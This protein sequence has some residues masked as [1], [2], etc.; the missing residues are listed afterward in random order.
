VAGY[1]PYQVV[2]GHPSGLIEYSTVRH[3]IPEESDSPEQTWCDFSVVT[4][5][6]GEPH[7]SLWADADH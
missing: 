5:V 4:G 2:A 1:Q 3:A 6:L 7:S